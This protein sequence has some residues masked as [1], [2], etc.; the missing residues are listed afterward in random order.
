MLKFGSTSARRKKAAG[1]GVLAYD[2]L[3]EVRNLRKWTR[4]GVYLAFSLPLPVYYVVG[5]SLV[6]VAV[7]MSMA[8]AIATAAVEGAFK[9]GFRIR[10][11]VAYPQIVINELSRDMAFLPAVERALHVVKALLGGEACFVALSFGGNDLEADLNVVAA[12]GTGREDARAFVRDFADQI[13]AA[14]LDQKVERVTL[15]EAVDDATH[16]ERRLTI[17][18]LVAMNRSIGVLGILEAERSPDLADDNLL[19]AMGTTLGLLLENLR[20][21]L[22]LQKSEERFRALI[23]HASDMIVIISEEATMRYVSPS[24]ERMLGYKPEEL[25][26]QNSFHL[27]HPDDLPQVL[28][29]YRRR[30]RTRGV[31]DPIEFRFRHRDGSWRVI[32]A[33]TNYDLLDDQS[34]AGIVV[35]GRDITDRKA[36]EA[37]LKESEERYRSLVETAHDAIYTLDREGRITSLN[38]AFERITGWSRGEWV[39]KPF[40]PLIHPEDLPR[41]TELFRRLLQGEQLGSYELRVR[42]RSG[43][44]LIGE[45]TSTAQVKDGEVVGVLGIARDVTDRRR[46]EEELRKREMQLAEAQRIAH[47]GSWEWDPEK[48]SITWSEE[49]YRIAGLSPGEEID[50]KRFLEIVHPEDRERLSGLFRQALASGS[51]I[52]DEYRLVRN[53]GSVRIV[54]GKGRVVN[55][56]GGNPVKMVGTAQDITERVRAEAAVRMSE[57][58]YRTLFERNLA[59]VYRTDLSGTI[60]DCNQSLARMLGFDSPEELWGRSALDF[61]LHPDVRH[62][63]VDEL[64]RGTVVTNFEVCLK[65]KDG[66]PVW[67]LENSSMLDDEEGGVIIEGT[68]IDISERK[69]AE[70]TIRH[71]AYHD[72]LTSLP[73]RSLFEEHLKLTVAHAQRSGEKL[74][75]LF[76][77]LDRF[78]GINDTLGHLGGDEVLK[79]ISARLSAIVREGDTVARVGGDEFVVMLRGVRDADE[80][81]EVADRIRVALAQPALVHGRELRVT[82]SIGVAIYPDHGSDVETLLRHADTAMYRAKE[83]GRDNACLYSPDLSFRWR[84]RMALE[85]DLLRAL[86]HDELVVYYQPIVELTSGRIVRAEALVRWKHP[87]RGLIYPGDFISVAEETGHVIRIGG[88]VLRTAAAA[89]RVWQNAGFHWVNLAVNISA[90]RFRQASVVDSIAEILEE[91]GLEA[92]K[93]QLEITENAIMQDVA[94]TVGILEELRRMGVQIAIDDF[95]TGY[96]SLAYLKRLPV[97]AVKIDCSFIRDLPTDPNT[98]TI[99]ATILAMARDLGLKVVAEGVETEEQLEYLRAR[100]CDEFQ[101]FYFS[102]AVP[103]DELRALLDSSRGRRAA[104]RRTPARRA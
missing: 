38:R 97:D 60:L 39:G 6:E 5:L 45:F 42:S 102:Q 82:A 27:I 49:L 83:H 36:A 90:S 29:L 98:A 7:V 13:R 64:R 77:D 18:P 37:T 65:R 103:L 15:S 56:A 43:D 74:A 20:Q 94:R 25:I 4:I 44:Y 12:H 57:R 54:H 89:A 11:R 85:A 14:A 17:V 22:D 55:D 34:V 95:G 75:V 8:F 70:E 58:R 51:E 71:M 67:V 23:E 99:V 61:Y 2:A 31:G 93:L 86:E 16:V 68:M 53:D 96:S 73:N 52:D 80:A 72:S 26:G 24:T 81:L 21:K 28:E 100:G 9:Q 91:T 101:G 79:A 87:R 33:I 88:H 78:K 46:A 62:K 66:S 76:L 19:S 41:A 3:R 10:K 69:R 1:E 92:K 32:E 30:L 63:F 48:G 35:N 47:L 50:A 59:G 84:R 40:A 104:P